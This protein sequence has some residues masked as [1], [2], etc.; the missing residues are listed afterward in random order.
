MLSRSPGGR[1]HLAQVGAQLRQRFPELKPSDLGYSKLTDLILAM[2]EVGRIE[3]HSPGTSE[4]VRVAPRLRH[5]LWSAV[6]E[7]D[8]A[9]RAWIDL[10]SE[11]LVTSQDD[12]EAEPERFLEVPRADLHRQREM[13]LEWIMGLEEEKRPPLLDALQD[14]DGLKP[15]LDLI[16]Q[17]DL[18][19]SWANHRTAAITSEVLTW[20]EA[21]GLEKRRLLDLESPR[22]RVLIDREPHATSE[23]ISHT[24]G[25]RMSEDELRHFL[26]LA[27]EQMSYHELQ[28]VWIPARVL[29]R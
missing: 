19:G 18:L 4:L 24:P 21:H 2:P 25:P 5:S 6:T 29:A 8:A 10:A 17:R 11:D 27:L 13:A 16:R 12:V 9:R 7:Y 20:A 28:Q 22:Q 23:R 14:H 26:H 3:E 15:F 1:I